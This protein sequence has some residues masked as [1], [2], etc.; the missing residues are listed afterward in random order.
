MQRTVRVAGMSW[1]IIAALLLIAASN[2]HAQETKSRLDIYGF[3]MMD[4]G[5]DFKQTDPAWFDVVRPTK[6]PSSE[7][8]FGE[9]AT[10][11]P[12]CGKAA[13]A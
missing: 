9:N 11:M 12:A 1:L 6:L 4:M 8:Q 7:K 10:P 2:P 3:A 13:W 5:I